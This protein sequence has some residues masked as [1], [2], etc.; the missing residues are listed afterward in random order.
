MSYSDFIMYADESGD[1][2]ISNLDPNYPL[3]VLNCCVFRKADY[4]AS[5][6]PAMATFKF[7]HFRHDDV[8]L[9]ENDIRRK[10]PP[11]VFLRDEKRRNTFMDGLDRLIAATDFTSIATVVDKSLLAN[12]NAG[13]SIAKNPYELALSSC[14]EQAYR[15]L[16]SKGH[17]EQVTHIVIEKRNGQLDRELERSFK[18]IRDGDNALGK[19]LN[20]EIVFADK[21]SNSA[22]LQI[23]DLI[24]RPIGLR[25][26]NPNQPN[27]AWNTMEAKL[28]RS[29]PSV[30]MDRGFTVL[31]G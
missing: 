30:A 10:A 20:F 9:H 7:E 22:G 28:F 1:H 4:V 12:Q 23:S 5:A 2:N 13:S 21:K 24:A 16:T 19:P 27:Q 18:A 8:V 11:F 3:F 14:L 31:P 25:Y 17:H 26:I 15:F 6:L 29:P